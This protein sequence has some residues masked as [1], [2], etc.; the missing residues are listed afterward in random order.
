VLPLCYRLDEFRQ[1]ACPRFCAFP[2]ILQFLAVAA[3]A[4]PI[5]S[6]LTSNFSLLYVRRPVSDYL[7][8]VPA[9]ALASRR[10]NDLRS[11]CWGAHDWTRWQH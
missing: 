4:Q 5:L 2:D 8:K 6:A 9:G 3:T 11:C 7:D 10:V 1:G